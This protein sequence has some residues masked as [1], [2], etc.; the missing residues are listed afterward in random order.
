MSHK[1]FCDVAGHWWECNGKAMRS[2][3]A[4]PSICMCLPCGRPV[5]GYDHS[6][7]NGPVELLA[8]PEHREE[9]RRRT[10]EAR[11]EYDRQRAEFGLDE[12]WA[13]MKSLPNGPEKDA[14]AEEFVEWLFR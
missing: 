11:K 13:R 14:L 1:H 2:G 4:E 12:K 3:D 10:V 7:C 6:R 9:E 5:E 8:C